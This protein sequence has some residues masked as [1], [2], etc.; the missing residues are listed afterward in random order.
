MRSR[1]ARVVGCVVVLTATFGLMR[2]V[3]ASDPGEPVV[4]VTGGLGNSLGILGFQGE[5]YLKRGRA[6]AFVGLGYSFDTG[7]SG[8][9]PTGIAGAAGFRLYTPGLKHRAFL[10][11]SVSELAKCAPY[12]GLEP[13]EGARSYGPGMQ[14][15]YQLVTR[16][17]FTLAASAGAG[18]A[19]GVDF[20]DKVF[21]TAGLAMGYTWRRP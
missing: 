7:E 11:A 4:T 3:H 8:M 1:R 20:G 21:M 15:G 13:V 6:S 5:R 17:G 9:L 10:E 14:L 19:P 2:A 12:Y 18:Y 16:S